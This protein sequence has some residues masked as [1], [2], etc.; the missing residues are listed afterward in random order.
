MDDYFDKTTTYN[1]VVNRIQQV[2]EEYAIKERKVFSYIYTITAL[3]LIA[4][5]FIMYLLKVE[6]VFYTI[7]LGIA[8]FIVFLIVLITKSTHKLYIM[9]KV[10]N[11]EIVNLYNTENGLNLEYQFKPKLPKTFNQEMGLFT[12]YAGVTSRYAIYDTTHKYPFQLYSCALVTSNG[13]SSTVHFDG[14]YTKFMIS[15]IPRQQLRSKGK[16]QTAGI[17]MVQVEG[18]EERFYIPLDK[19]D[20]RIN[21]ILQGI[22]QDMPNRFDLKAYYI[23]SNDFEVHIA[24]TPRN[25]QKLPDTISYQSIQ[26]YAEPLLDYLSF[27]QE[28]RIQ[29]VEMGLPD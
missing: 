28:V 26:D 9:N 10:L 25:R 23:G 17:K 18:N 14:I 19:P 12:K 29:I 16:P 13:K 27:V 20:T 24:F 11:E 2:K 6:L 5:F 3:L 8:L 15:S 22:F 21:S 1:S 4:C 7:P